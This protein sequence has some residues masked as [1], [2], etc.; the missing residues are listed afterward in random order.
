[1]T[2]KNK[3]AKELLQRYIA[4]QSGKSERLLLED[5]YN[6]LQFTRHPAEE[7]MLRED[8]EASLLQFRKEHQRV[9]KLRSFRRTVAAAAL[10]LLFLAGTLLLQNSRDSKTE[11]I[12]GRD[13]IMPG[14][15][16]ATLIIGGNKKIA[17][18]Q[19]TIGSIETVTG[20]NISK[21]SENQI[22]YTTASDDVNPTNTLLTANGQ[23]FSIKLSDGTLVYLNASSSIS[24]KS[25]IQSGGKRE[26]QLSGEAYFEV[27]KDAKHPFIV[28]TNG[29]RIRVLGT[30]FNI[31][32]YSNE[33]YV[34]TTL[35][36]GSVMVSTGNSSLMLR[37]GEQARLSLSNA[38]LNKR[39]VDAD[40]EIAWKNGILS[41]NGEDIYVI[42]RQ[43]AR[44]YNLTVSYDEDLPREKFYGQLSRNSPLPEVLK[45][46]AMNNL[47]FRQEGRN[48]HVSIKKQ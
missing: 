37:P 10:I 47:Q 18:N 21:V 39:A 6:Q 41:F 17:L 5:W 14:S 43:L 9:K 40:E 36:E 3:R 44:W 34:K 35:L 45:I 28:E 42:M 20:L 29:Q 33:S 4:G 8:Q 30:H 24:Y 48:I 15:S 11:Y 25:N 19:Q 31:N 1:M 2:D 7:S 16:G 46:L 22:D 32:A 26:V 13:K 12:S 38:V 23:T 27:A